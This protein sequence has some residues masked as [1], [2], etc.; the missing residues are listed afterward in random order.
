VHSGDNKIPGIPNHN[1]GKHAPKQYRANADCL[2]A[3]QAELGWLE[4]PCQQSY[5]D[6]GKDKLD[7]SILGHQL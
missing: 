6:E 3:E 5:Y 2:P 4:P 1:S 7:G